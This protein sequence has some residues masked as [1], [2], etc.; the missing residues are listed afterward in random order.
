M[1]A[2]ASNFFLPVFLRLPSKNTQQKRTILSYH[3]SFRILNELGNIIHNNAMY[4]GEAFIL[5]SFSNGFSFS[6]TFFSSFLSSSSVWDAFSISVCFRVYTDIYWAFKFFLP[7]SVFCLW[8]W[9]NVWHDVSSSQSD[10][11][12][13][14]KRLST[15]T[16]FHFRL[17]FLL[18]SILLV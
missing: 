2:F 1:T 4:S 6:A 9:I 3:I 18:R 13:Q 5:L 11:R 12:N 8:N 7:L 15:L 10:S 16:N 14:I 17:L